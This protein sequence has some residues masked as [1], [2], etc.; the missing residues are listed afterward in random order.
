MIAKFFAI[1]NALIDILSKVL[2]RTVAILV[3][4]VLGIVLILTL[5][6]EL[7]VHAFN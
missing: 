1:L 6:T 7:I 3:L 5:S 2:I 4:L